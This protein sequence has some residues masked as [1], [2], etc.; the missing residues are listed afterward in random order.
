MLNSLL[1]I[2]ESALNAAQAW[3]SVT[4]N[5]LAN[6]DT[7]GYSRQYVD[8]RDAYAITRKP[9]A[10]G[11]GV[12]VQ[13]VLRFFDA[14]LES[15]YVRQSTT[16]ARWDEHDKV[17]TTLENLF[18][19]SNRTGISSLIT[20]FFGAWSDLALRPDD[21]AT[22]ESLLAYADNL[23]TMMTST[24]D[25]I[26]N[27]QREMTQNI[28]TNVDRVNEISQAIADLNQQISVHTIKGVS[29]PN[30]LLD[31]RD[32]LV[33]ELAT[34]VD[35]ETYDQGA[36]DFRVQ[37]TTGQPLVEGINT[38]KLAVMGPQAET[39]EQLPP[40]TGTATNANLVFSGSD[41][42]E[43]TVDIITGG[44]VGTAQFRVSF[45]GGKTWLRDEDGQELHFDITDND[46]DG[47]V[48][49]VLVKDV[50]ITFEPEGQNQ[51]IADLNF[52]VG[53]KF[54]VV[55]KDGLYWIEPTRGPENI[56]PQIYFDG[57]DNPDRV[58]GGAIAAEFNIRDDNCGRYLD[59][60]NAVASSLIWEV[61][62]IHSQG[63]GLEML[64]YAQGEQKVN[65]KQPLGDAQSLLPYYDRL[66]E[67]NFTMHIY[68]KNTGEYVNSGVL[69]FDW[70]N[71]GLPGTAVTNFNPDVHSLEDV[72]QAINN[73]LVDDNGDPVLVY[74]S[75]GNQV[76]PLIASIV[77]G[78]ISIQVNPDADITFA[79]GQDSTG[80]LAALGLNTFFS[81]SNAETISVNSRLHSNTNLV[82]SGQVNGQ[83]QANV[84]DPIMAQNIAALI[85]KEVTISPMW[86][87]SKTQTFSEYYANL[88]STVG[89]DRRT[90]KTNLE[91]NTTLSDDLAAR[92]ASVTG[93]N[94]DE[95][96]AN[97]I[98]YQHSYTAA[99]KLITTAD[100]M[101][102]TLLGLKQ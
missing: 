67:G 41:S 54:D 86:K 84:G 38:W 45:D 85:D 12:S 51:T 30:S 73:G 46:G 8:Q 57:T 90:S 89:A 94:M 31:Q 7:E 76:K 56:T 58:T 69:N 24:V 26:H 92:V 96:M 21:T 88:V 98:K 49:S 22:R 83:H 34:L 91:Y 77:D 52:N 82:N 9:G 64:T 47:N 37:L 81:G 15:S 5:N 93:V 74:D 40:S 19:E 17:M 42:H 53:D 78:K 20:D 102:Q 28:R 44:G 99:A 3:I 101:L 10:Q 29:N 72:V 32:Q 55:P 79:F 97:L 4:G 23:N 68:D 95:E 27:I 16:T 59:E 62:R 87:T 66:Q 6:A 14:F 25:E 80:L 11:M 65:E 1:S 33:R 39:R 2:G 100:Q 75:S 35:V 18:N 71:A 36:G 60:L 50:T 61:N 63:T 70:S 43:Y 48:D 13:Q